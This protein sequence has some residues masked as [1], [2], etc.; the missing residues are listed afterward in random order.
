MGTAPRVLVAGMSRNARSLSPAGHRRSI[1]DYDSL[2]ESS[3][4]ESAGPRIRGKRVG[5]QLL[6][7]TVVL[8][9]KNEERVE[10]RWQTFNTSGYR[11]LLEGPIR[12]GS[13]ARKSNAFPA[14]AERAVTARLE[15]L[16]VP[17]ERGARKAGLPRSAAASSDILPGGRA[18]SSGWNDSAGMASKSLLPHSGGATGAG[19]KDMYNRQVE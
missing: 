6:D 2:N 18:S 16:S 1:F 15:A 17:K 4:G 5:V 13:C 9:R 10:A 12:P 7:P 14:K 3:D 11:G 8:S 19:Y